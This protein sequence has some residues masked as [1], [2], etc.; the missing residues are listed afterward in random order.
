MAQFKLGC[1]AF[2]S[3]LAAVSTA[4]AGSIAD[5]GNIN[6]EADATCRT[7]VGITCEGHC[8]ISSC[9]AELY[10][11]CTGKCVGTLPDCEASCSGTCEG[12]CQA[13][14]NFDCSATCNTTCKGDCAGT[15][16]SKCA[17]N[18]T[19]ADCQAQCEGTCKATCEGECSASCSGTA[20]AT[21]QGKCSA[22]CQGRCNGQARLE[23]EL[24]CAPPSAYVECQGECKASCNTTEGAFFCD[25]NYVDHGGH[26]SSCVDAI[27]ALLPTVT[28]DLSGS[29]SAGCQGNT[30]TAQAEGKASASCAV[31]RV[32][33]RHRLG[34]MGLL[35][36]GLG[37]L[38]SARRRRN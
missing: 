32:G 24:A 36:V 19:G 18:N 31:A 5:C 34:G 3:V 28:V 23:C 2:L 17:S 27:E 6:V 8:Q 35:I 38:A 25:G 4:R 26:L 21:C 13:N 11:G 7:E 16:Q 33:S 37:L 10:G 22:S 20:Q 30:C 12:E 29:S 15:C 1:V 14:A 9:S